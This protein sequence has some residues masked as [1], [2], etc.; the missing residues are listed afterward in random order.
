M[1]HRLIALPIVFALPLLPGAAV[2]AATPSAGPSMDRTRAV[3]RAFL[4]QFQRVRQRLC[5]GTGIAPS[6]STAR[7]SRDPCLV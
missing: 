7:S 2:S 3:A 6:G 5:M 4:E 1:G